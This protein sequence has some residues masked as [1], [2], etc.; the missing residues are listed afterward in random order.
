ML[1]EQRILRSPGYRPEECPE[2]GSSGLVTDSDSG[3]IICHACGLVV[4]DKVIDEKPEWRAFTPEERTART[5]VGGPSRLSHFD[6]GLSTTFQTNEDASGK[7]LPPSTRS[8]M[9]RLR[10]WDAR[11]RVH[12]SVRN[13][14]LAMSE[15]DRLSDKLSIPGPTKEEAALIYRKALK[16]GLVRGRSITGIVA[17]SLYSACRLTNTSRRLDDFAKATTENRKN[18]TRDYRLLVRELYLKMPVDDPERLIS[19]I[20]SR[21][22]TSQT[23]QNKAAQI[24]RKAKATFLIAGKDPSGIAA[25]AIYIASIMEGEKTSQKQLAAAAGVTE[26]TVRNRY[27][28][29]ARGLHMRDILS[30]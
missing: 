10:R 7:T 4:S 30:V 9:I 20:A 23:T 19:K 16:A 22:H 24:L 18:F 11:A 8:T 5:R 25:A 26:V 17:A 12:S 6:K 28:G 21:T 1:A 2:C 3:E 29:L 13:L 14:S 15:L 27:K